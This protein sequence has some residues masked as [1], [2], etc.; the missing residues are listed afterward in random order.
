MNRPDPSQPPTPQDKFTRAGSIAIEFAACLM[1][2]AC[3]WA[4]MALMASFIT[5]QNQFAD[6]EAMPILRGLLLIGFA[7]A[8]VRTAALIRNNKI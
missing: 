8:S 4:M 7:A 5:W 2:A 1:I 3:I 6:A